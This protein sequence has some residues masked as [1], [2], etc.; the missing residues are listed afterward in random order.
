M[1]PTTQHINN[2]S[3]PLIFLGTNQCLGKYIDV[4]VENG[5]QIHGIIDSDYYGNTECF[6]GIPVIDSEQGLIDKVDYYKNFNFFCATNW[7]PELAPIPTRNREKRFRQINLLDSLELDVVSLTDARAK[8]SSTCRIGRGCFIDCFALIEPHCVLD[9]Y[10]NIYAYVGLGHHS[11]VDRNTVIQRHCSI[12][13]TVHFQE[14]CFLGVAVKALKTKA[15]FGK[16]T[17]IHECIYIRRGTVADEVVGLNGSNMSRVYS[18][19]DRQ[20]E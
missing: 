14:N 2:T 1:Q 9:D 7:G 12:A 11:Q 8:I 15:V 13:G 19:D 4:C 6:D 5:I 18:E 17:F 20:A 10:V 16:N 3:K